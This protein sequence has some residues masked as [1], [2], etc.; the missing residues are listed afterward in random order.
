M[1]PRPVYIRGVGAVT[2]LGLTWAESAAALATG[3]T[4]VRAV[5]GCDVAGYPCT[6][7]AQITAPLPDPDEPDRRLALLRPAAAAA[8]Q[9]A[10]LEVPKERLGVFIGA[11][12][13][14]A[15]LS[16]L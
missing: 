7:A 12:S 13:G 4:A 8:W 16:T 14:R 9:E 3:V 1:A 15:T 10:Q 2:P 6:V 11:E 5:T